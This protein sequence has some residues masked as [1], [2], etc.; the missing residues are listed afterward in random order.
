MN[1]MGINMLQESMKRD[2]DY[3]VI[4]FTSPQKNMR[5]WVADFRFIL[6]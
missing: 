1:F 2:A 6:R 3:C 4:N 5:R